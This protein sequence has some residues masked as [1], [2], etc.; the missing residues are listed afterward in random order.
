MEQENPKEKSRLK[1]IPDHIR[2]FIKTKLAYYKLVAV[3]GA[4]KASAAATT[5]ILLFLIGLFFLIFLFAGLAL[6]IGSAIGSAGGGFLIVAGFFL[7]LIVLIIL[8]NNPLIKK[9]V[10]RMVISA[11][12]GNTSH[13]EPNE[14][15]QPGEPAS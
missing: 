7:L 8:L 4:A 14:N 2:A 15:K 5:G 3:E 9:P 6:L 13:D 11:L 1:E 10:T 12:A